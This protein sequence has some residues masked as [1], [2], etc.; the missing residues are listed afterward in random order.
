MWYIFTV[1]IIQSEYKINY[2]VD[3]VNFVYDICTISGNSSTYIIP[4]SAGFWVN[5]LHLNFCNVLALY[6]LKKIAIYWYKPELKSSDFIGQ[7]TT[8]TV[9]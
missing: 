2:N 7:F 8:S 3:K 9:D 4:K 5:Q 6:Q 1:I